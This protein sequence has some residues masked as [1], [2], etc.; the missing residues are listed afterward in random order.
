[1]KDLQFIIDTKSITEY[2]K[3]KRDSTKTLSSQNK[4]FFVGHNF[5][6]HEVLCCHFRKSFGP[7]H[8]FAAIQHKNM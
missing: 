2:F 5:G 8:F 1:M 3:Q 4:T 7:S 6:L